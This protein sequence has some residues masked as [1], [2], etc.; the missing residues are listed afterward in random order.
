MVRYIENI[1][2]NAPFLSF[3]DLD[4]TNSI[5]SYSEIPAKNETVEN[6]GKNKD[7]NSSIIILEDIREKDQDIPTAEKKIQ[8]KN[9]DKS[10]ATIVIDIE[11]ST[12]SVYH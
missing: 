10:G 7:F 8:L 2:Q 1:D 11:K 12:P 9:K 6:K 3:S 4:D 5:C